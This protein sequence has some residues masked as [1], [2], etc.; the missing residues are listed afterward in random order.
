METFKC[1]KCKIDVV[2]S[3]CKN[4]SMMCFSCNTQ[5]LKKKQKELMR[6]YYIKN[7]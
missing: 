4:R 6:Q 7:R 2:K 5:K 1:S 3:E